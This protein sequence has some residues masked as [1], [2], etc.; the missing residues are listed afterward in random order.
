M[1]TP[2]GVSFLSVFRMVPVL[3]KK[4]VTV[5]PVTITMMVN[6]TDV[7]SVPGFTWKRRYKPDCLLVQ[8]KPLTAPC[9]SGAITRCHSHPLVRPR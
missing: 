1:P 7:T 3:G 6:L 8:L 9:F 5:V 2:A 4:V